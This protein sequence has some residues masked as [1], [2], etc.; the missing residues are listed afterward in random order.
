MVGRH[1]RIPAQDQRTSMWEAPEAPRTPAPSSETTFLQG[2]VPAVQKP[3]MLSKKHN[4]KPNPVAALA[5]K[6][7]AWKEMK[8]AQTTRNAKPATG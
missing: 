8:S 6:G 7:S 4:T 5:E 2:M 1:P 3:R